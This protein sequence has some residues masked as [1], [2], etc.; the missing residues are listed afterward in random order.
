ML[1]NDFCVFCCQILSL[2]GAL[3]VCGSIKPNC[4]A[5]QSA[6]KLQRRSCTWMESDCVGILGTGVEDNG[7]LALARG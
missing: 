3:A 1:C 6:R 4:Y 2:R 5:V 7:G